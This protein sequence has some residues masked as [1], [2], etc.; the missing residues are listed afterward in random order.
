MVG[1]V[2]VMIV[3]MIIYD[4]GDSDTYDNKG[5]DDVDDTDDD[6]YDDNVDDDDGSDDDDDNDRDNGND[7]DY[8]D[9]DDIVDAP[10]LHVPAGYAVASSQ[11]ESHHKHQGAKTTVHPNLKKD[12][13]TAELE[14]GRTCPKSPS[15]NFFV[16]VVLV[17]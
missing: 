1:D 8:G 15:L 14:I 3:T 16:V 10:A 6:A 7:D 11:Y 5:I 4:D 9:N 12:H 2:V 13:C 17:P